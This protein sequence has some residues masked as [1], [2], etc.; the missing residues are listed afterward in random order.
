MNHSRQGFIC[1][2][3]C[4]L[5]EPFFAFWPESDNQQ[6]KVAPESDLKSTIYIELFVAIYLCF[7]SFNPTDYDYTQVL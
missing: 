3:T 4:F 2:G 6:I 1:L 7:P 5:H